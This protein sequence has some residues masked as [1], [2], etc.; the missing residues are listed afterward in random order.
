MAMQKCVECGHEISAQAKACVN[1]GH[2]LKRS[3][4]A[5]ILMLIVGIPVAGFAALV[6]FGAIIGPSEVSLRERIDR[7]CQEQFGDRGEAAVT[8]CR[9]R[10]S[11]EALGQA[12]RER[13]ER[14]RNGGR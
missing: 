7:S 9:L 3:S 12:E 1:C 10:L 2:P 13:L 11:V 5:R 14:A 6:I 8:E 4:G